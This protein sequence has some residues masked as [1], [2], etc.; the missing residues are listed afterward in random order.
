VLSI[1][2]VS[3]QDGRLDVDARYAIANT[4]EAIIAFVKV[5]ALLNV[6]FISRT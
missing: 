1:A 5:G 4:A 6:S 2:T 3:L